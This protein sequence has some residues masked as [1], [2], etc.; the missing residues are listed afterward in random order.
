M[1]GSE[2]GKT[3]HSRNTNGPHG[4]GNGDRNAGRKVCGRVVKATVVWGPKKKWWYKWG[5]PREE[6]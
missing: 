1:Y 5:N 4:G 3:W 6:T 2:T